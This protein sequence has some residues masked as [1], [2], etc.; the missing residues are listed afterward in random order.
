MITNPYQKGIFPDRK[1]KRKHVMSILP[2]LPSLKIWRRCSTYLCRQVQIP[3]QSLSMKSARMRPLATSTFQTPKH[4]SIP[5]TVITIYFGEVVAFSL[6][7]DAVNQRL[8]TSNFM[9]YSISTPFVI[10]HNIR[11]GICPSP[12]LASPRLSSPRRK[13]KGE[14][15]KAK[16]ERRKAKAKIC[17]D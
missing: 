15:R 1:K 6:K 14:R 16:G 12:R 5:M 8:T 4:S 17:K 2:I 13:A 3:G 7:K 10:P 11:E 9:M